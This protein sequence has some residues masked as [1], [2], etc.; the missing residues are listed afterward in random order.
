MGTAYFI[1]KPAK[2]IY[3]A[4]ATISPTDP[5]IVEHVPLAEVA[6]ALVQYCEAH[7]GANEDY[8]LTAREADEAVRCW[9]YGAPG[10]PAPKS[11]AWPGDKGLAFTRLPWL[12]AVAEA[13]TWEK[14]IGRMTNADAFCA[15]VGSLFDEKSYLQ[16]YV[17]LYGKGN[18]G[19]G[20]INRFLARIFGPAYCSKQPRERGDKFW[21]HELLG[22]R[23]VVF[24]DCNDESFIT[25]GLFK[26][27]T[28]GD[29][30]PV[31]AKGEMAYTTRINAKY[32]VISN[33]KPNLSSETADR[34]RII[35][36]EMR[37][38][39]E[40]Q[41]EPGFEDRL[42]EEGGNF[43][44]IC[45]NFYESTGGR[46][47]ACDDDDMLDWINTV[48]G[49]YAEVFDHY[50]SVDELFTKEAVDAKKHLWATPLG[51]QRVLKAAFKSRK[52]Q[53]KFLSWMER[54]KGIFK[55]TV[56]FDNAEF[57]KLYA[58]LI[59]KPFLELLDGKTVCVRE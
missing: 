58:G 39:P 46:R 51:V 6:S 10:R 4:L 43:L 52:D 59:A 18:E 5:E 41:D 20:A 11:F 57:P 12:P 1:T 29:P 15:W 8:Q 26:S 54:E 55:R 35:Y 2:G 13:P 34:R 3:K 28:G 48:E 56:R 21:T 32:L 50:F 31:E 25:S 37:P 40:E 17:W 27:M 23:L 30:V 42:W 33:S 9:A 44:G 19:K 16:Q 36:C 47:I 53:L 24:P 14:I 22:K 49:D 45:Q 38:R 7:L